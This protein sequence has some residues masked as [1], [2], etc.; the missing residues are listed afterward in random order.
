MIAGMVS[1]DMQEPC[2]PGGGG[3]PIMGG[4]GGLDPG[5]RGIPG[6]GGRA[7]PAARTGAPC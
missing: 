7:K 4:I 5:G 6:M 2:S 3:P 1:L